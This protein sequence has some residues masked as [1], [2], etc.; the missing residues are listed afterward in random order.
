MI[1]KNIWSKSNHTK[2]LFQLFIL[3]LSINSHKE[4][5]K[6]QLCCIYCR[7]LKQ[8]RSWNVQWRMCIPLSLSQTHTHTHTITLNTH[9]RTDTPLS[10]TPTL[11]PTLAHTHTHT[12]IH[13]HIHTLSLSLSL[14][15]PITL[16]N[17]VWSLSRK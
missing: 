1:D 16:C 3:S 8:S 14:S 9:L 2:R 13:T 12:P 10:H 6:L 7:T 5:M 4:L 11:T 17:I 15:Y